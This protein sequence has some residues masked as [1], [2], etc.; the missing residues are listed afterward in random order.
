MRDLRGW[1]VDIGQ[2]EG[3]DGDFP[4]LEFRE[5]LE[6]LLNRL[7]RYSLG[8]FADTGELRSPAQHC[9]RS[10]A[11]ID[12]EI[13]QPPRYCCDE[14]G[15]VG[16]EDRDEGSLRHNDLAMAGDGTAS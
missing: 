7:H 8:Q 14:T 16:A 3:R 13:V 10:V 2:N 12:A 6:V 1:P 15:A 9:K 11:K 5:A 4:A